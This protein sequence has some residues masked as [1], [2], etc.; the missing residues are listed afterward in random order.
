MTAAAVVD[1]SFAEVQRAVDAEN[2]ATA[3]AKR[4]AAT[5]AK[6]AKPS[7]ATE[8]DNRVGKPQCPHTSGILVAKDEVDSRN[9]HIHT[10]RKP[11]KTNNTTT[12]KQKT[13]AV[14]AS[15]VDSSW[16]QHP[17][18]LETHHQA[19]KEMIRNNP[20]VQQKT[21]RKDRSI[22]APPVDVKPQPS[23]QW[24]MD[25]YE[26]PPIPPPWP[27][28][29]QRQQMCQE[30]SGKKPGEHLGPMAARWVS[31]L[32][33]WYRQLQGYFQFDPSNLAGNVR[34]S[35]E[36]WRRR[37]QYLRIE[38]EHTFEYVMDLIERGHFIPFER[39]PKP[40]FRQHNPP[41]LAEDKDRAWDAIKGD[42]EHG[43]IEPV[44]IAK[45]GIPHCVCPV[46]TAEKANGKARF[47]HNS[48]HVNK[49]VPKAEGE[50]TLESLLKTRNMYTRNGFVIGSDFASG[51]HCIFMR[52]DQRTY[53]AFALHRSEIPD[54]A[55]KWLLKH[56][57]E[58]YHA[59]KRSFIFRYCA[60]PFGLTTS[61]KA[62]N[63]LITSLMGFWRRCACGGLPTRVSSYIDDLLSAHQTFDSAMAMAIRMVYESAALGLSLKIEKCS[64]FPKHSIKALGTIIDLQ[65]FTFKVAQSRNDK[66]HAAIRKL[67]QSVALNRQRVPARLVAS[68]VGLIW[69]IA[70]C[71]HRAASV[72]VRAMTATLAEGIRRGMSKQDHIPMRTILTRFWSGT[73]RWTP[74]AQRQLEFWAKVNFMKL[75][76]PISTDVLGKSLEAMFAKPWL[77]N[78]DNVTC[79]FQDASETASG[80]GTLKP[81]PSGMI[82]TSDL[83]L[84]MFSELE[85]EMSSTLRELLGIMW[86]LEA[87]ITHETTR[88]VFAC[89]N[90]GSVNAIRF[91]SRTPCIQA[92]AERIFAIC[93][94]HNVVCWPVWLPRSSL[95]ITEADRR[96]RL[97]IPHDDRTPP[98]VVNICNEIAL[99][100]W[101]RPMSFDQ[102]ASHLSTIKIGGTKLPFNAFCLQPGAHGVDMFLQHQ[103][104]VQN[105]NFVHPPKPM[106]GRLLSFLQST[107][108]RSIVT[109]PT[110]K[111]T[112]WWSYMTEP[113][114][115]GLI[116][117]QSA[118]G[119]TILAYDFSYRT[120]PKQAFT[121]HR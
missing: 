70:A 54:D 33:E 40:F 41:S 52:E 64:F 21:L 49:R 22:F 32:K 81:G 8:P 62:F 35:K 15:A 39:E 93:L 50:C 48:R 88:I 121:S 55:F 58:A 80:G 102:A 78:H 26:T 44:D 117:K 73:V 71:C 114:A 61:C 25:S 57:P 75:E 5:Q 120:A 13:A 17:R 19:V 18:R 95:V 23:E 90:Y 6:A 56:Y 97:R 111:T 103:S 27:T 85:T 99:R 37:L 72:M 109:F 9:I 100:V 38:D 86:C 53:L 76:A 68:L 34:R 20:D 79:L 14:M 31:D 16:F 51:Y 30:S 7:Q 11:E 12:K 43:A 87:A 24:P 77:V 82:P 59:K 42:I 36:R 91:G 96:S 84:A 107:R 112:A 29:R 108:S 67:R 105:I 1:T 101:G 98:A 60:L 45:H 66:L 2:P 94:R 118:F 106:T 119:F 83:F 74:A 115:E 10:K 69:S 89:D 113:N 47:V 110:R 3:R 116:E 4:A 63:T 28:A 65:S 46:R 92:V 104:W